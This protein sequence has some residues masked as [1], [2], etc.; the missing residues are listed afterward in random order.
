MGKIPVTDY[1]IIVSKSE[2]HPQAKLYGFSI[3]ETIAVFPLP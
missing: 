1:Q 2:T 3:R